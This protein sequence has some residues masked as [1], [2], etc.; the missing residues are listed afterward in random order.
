MPP[1]LAH[2]GRARAGAARHRRATRSRRHRRHHPSP[3]QTPART[4]GGGD[5][6]NGT[7]MAKK[8]DGRQQAPHPR[9]P[10]QGESWRA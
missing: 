9:R 10:A 8:G 1:P 6:R 2:G 7:A 4:G 3:R 5:G